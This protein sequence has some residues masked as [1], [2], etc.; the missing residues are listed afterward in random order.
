MAHPMMKCGHAA[1]ATNQKT[2]KPSCAICAG[3]RPE[4]NIIDDDPP[5]LTGRTARCNYYGTTPKGRNHEGPAGCERGKPCM[6]E[7]PSSPDL[8]FFTH[9]PDKDHDSFFCGCWGWS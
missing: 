2:G 8:A 3:L 9:N 5:D 4:A 7:R 6:C 1:N